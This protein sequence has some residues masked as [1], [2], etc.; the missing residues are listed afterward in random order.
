MKNLIKLCALA[1]AIALSIAAS[2]A[3]TSDQEKDFVDQYKRAF[4]GSDAA[5]LESLLYTKDADPNALKFYK[6]MLITEMGSK[7]SNIELRNLTPDEAKKAAEIQPSPDGGKSKL[8]V[9]PSK[10]LVL[11]IETKDE[12]GT[13]SSSSE[14]FVAEVDGKLLIPV[15]V[16]VQ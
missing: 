3:S 11:K 5:K 4:E 16:A 6:M 2:F 9:M 8:S 1:V 10:K 15:P 14:S 12:N 13:S 7:L